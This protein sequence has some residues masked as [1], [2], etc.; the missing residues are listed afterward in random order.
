LH[1]Q[2]LDAALT[3]HQ[4]YPILKE[5]WQLQSFSGE[6]KKEAFCKWHYERHLEGTDGASQ[7]RAIRRARKLHN[8]YEGS[9]NFAEQAPCTT[10]YLLVEELTKT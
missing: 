1:Y 8:A 9:Q 4:L 5:R 6:A 2:T 3:R 10:V 7:E